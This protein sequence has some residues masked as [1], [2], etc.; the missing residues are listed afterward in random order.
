MVERGFLEWLESTRARP[1]SVNF[2]LSRDELAR[3][4]QSSPGADETVM[5]LVIT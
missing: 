1:V 2:A 3:T 4:V 5:F